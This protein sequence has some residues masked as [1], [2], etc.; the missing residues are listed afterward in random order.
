MLKFY[1][2]FFTLRANQL[3]RIKKN[4]FSGFSSEI[5]QVFTQIFFPSFSRGRL[6]VRENERLEAQMHEAARNNEDVEF[7]YI[8]IMKYTFY[9][10][11]KQIT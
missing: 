2:I 11:Q 1:K 9:F 6:L 4:I 7:F 5:M 10:E 3:K 8:F